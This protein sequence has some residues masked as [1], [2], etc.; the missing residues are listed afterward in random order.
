MWELLLVMLER[1]A[2]IVTVAFI[3]TRFSFVRSIIEQKDISF[4]Q[5]LAVVIIFGCFGIIGT[6]TGLAVDTEGGVYSRWT[7]TL[8]DNEAIA[9]SRVVGIV[10]A[11]LLGGWKV[12]IGAGLLAGFHR[13]TLGGFSDLAC[14]IST[15]VA[16]AIAG[17]FYKRNE[18]QRMI[19]WQTALVVGMVAEAVQMF[20]ILGIAR[21]FEQAWSLVSGIGLP[22]IFANG[23]GAALFILIIRNVVSEEERMG[24]IQAQRALRLADQT[25][26]H[27]RKGLS[28]ESAQ[29]TCSIL[30]KEIDVAAV[31]M[32]NRKEVLAFVG[33]GKWRHQNNPII[34]TLATKEVLKTGTLKLAN[35]DDIFN[36]EENFPLRAAVIAPL[37]QNHETIG[38]LKFYFRTEKERT[39]TTIE[40]SKGLATLLSHQLELSEM[41]RH[42]ELAKQAEIKAPQAQVHPHFLFNALNTI[43]SL[44][45]TDPAKAR[46]L[47]ISLSRF[48]RQNLSGVNKTEASLEEELAHVKAYLLIEETRFSDRLSII[49]EVDQLVLDA[50]VPPMTLQPIVENAMKHGL[51]DHVGECQLR[52]RI[53]KQPKGVRVQI[54]DNGIGMSQERLKQLFESPVTSET[55]TGIG[56]YNVKRRLDMMYGERYSFELTSEKD[57][58]TV[59]TIDLER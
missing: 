21:P 9:N 55:G 15:V 8:Q 32:T 34:Q 2:I 7:L 20:I 41:D 52:I 51:K 26:K 28:K 19:S 40:L 36:E 42:L 29:A 23:I 54:L 39:E 56:L 33:V 30:L 44:I 59:W 49:Y 17:Y 11:G 22:M 47:L 50:I 57:V 4:W 12:G 58:G 24:T 38:T 31:S 43:V 16:G 5:R 14:G 10:V 48:F 25:L 18:N 37:K 6:Y 1:L 35:E 3:M 46:Q 53:K 13:F 27:M 45:R